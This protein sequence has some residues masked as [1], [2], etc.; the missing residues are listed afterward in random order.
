MKHP[1]TTHPSIYNMGSANNHGH[2][3]LVDKHYDVIVAIGFFWYIIQYDVAPLDVFDDL[4]GK[5]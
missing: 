2:Q 4:L 3:L 5:P 1:T